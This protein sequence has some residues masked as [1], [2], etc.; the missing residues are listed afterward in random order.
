MYKIDAFVRIECIDKRFPSIVTFH[1]KEL[2]GLPE[3]PTMESL[4]NGEKLGEPVAIMVGGQGFPITFS[5]K[6]PLKDGSQYREYRFKYTSTLPGVIDDT[7]KL[8]ESDPL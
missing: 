7:R 3:L 4:H 6:G 8:F 5:H 1:K 2:V